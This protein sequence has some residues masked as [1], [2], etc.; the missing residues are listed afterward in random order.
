[1]PLAPVRQQRNTAVWLYWR[2]VAGIG[3]G[4]R[5]L[6]QFIAFG[7]ITVIHAVPQEV[8]MSDRAAKGIRQITSSGAY[9][10]LWQ[11]AANVRSAVQSVITDG[12]TP[13]CIYGDRLS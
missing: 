5:G 10:A 11:A 6:H 9:R 3:S 7:Y 12:S 8:V 2:R 1:M 4:N 13:A